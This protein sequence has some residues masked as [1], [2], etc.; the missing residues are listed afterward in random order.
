MKD[1]IGYIRE[2]F[3]YSGDGF[4]IS[5]LCMVNKIKSSSI[6]PLL[7]SNIWMKTLKKKKGSP[8]ILDNYGEIF[9]VSIRS[10]I[11][12]KLI[13]NRIR[14]TLR[15]NISQ[16]QSGGMKGR[17]L[18]DNLFIIRSVIDHALYVGKGTMYHIL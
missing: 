8:K 14:S 15:N 10:I 16:F 3:K 9:V 11:L 12:E 17:G 1:P 18:V 6:L 7:W 5:L 2:I 13:K 4:L